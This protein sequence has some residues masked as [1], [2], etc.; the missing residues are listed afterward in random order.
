M[1]TESRNWNGAQTVSDGLMDRARLNRLY[2]HSEDE[3]DLVA[4]QRAGLRTTSVTVDAL[5]EKI[6]LLAEQA[7]ARKATETPTQR[8]RRE[9]VQN[10]WFDEEERIASGIGSFRQSELAR[11]LAARRIA[12]DQA[13]SYDVDYEVEV[14]LAGMDLRLRQG[15]HIVARELLARCKTIDRGFLA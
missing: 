2:Q 1:R 9:E 11:Q 7:L 10:R 5:E 4:R 13:D 15:N 6:T 8:K 14:E 12:T 3:F